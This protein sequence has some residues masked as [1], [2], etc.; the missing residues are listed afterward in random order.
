MK[1]IKK[2]ALFATASSVFFT[3]ISCLATSENST[4]SSTC[5][6]FVTPSGIKSQDI[7][8]SVDKLMSKFINK[9]I[10]GAQVSVTK[11]GKEVFSKG[12]GLANRKTPIPV[13]TNTSFNY[14]SVSKLFIWV[15]AMQLVEQGKLDLNKDIR[16]YLPKDYPLHITSKKPVTFLNLMNHNAGFEAFWKYYGGSGGSRDFSSLE[17][18]VHKCYSTIQCF[19]PGEF[20]GYSNFGANLAAL[21]I[22][23]ISKTPYF[24]YVDKNIFKPCKM[25]TCYPEREPIK[26]V[27]KNKATGYRF[28]RGNF[29]LTSVYSGDW[30]YPSGSAVGT[31]N[32]LSKFA[33][34]LMPEKSKKSPLFKSNK[35]LEEMF[36]ISYTP[37]GKDLFSMHHGFWGPN[38]NYSG[39]GHTGC[40]DGMVSHFVIV[41]KERFSVAVLVNDENG[42]DVAYG[43]TSLLTGSEYNKSR[44]KFDKVNT[45]T[46]EGDYVHARTRFANRARDFDLIHVK[47]LANGHDIELKLNNNPQIYRQIEP[48]LFENITATHGI[49]YK[50]KIYFKVKNGSVEKI[51]TFKNDLIPISKL[52]K[53]RSKF[54]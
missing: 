10:S 24:E 26:N 28:N 38:G 46:L 3:P 49:D 4:V 7:E 1:A 31:A 47:S 39:M 45:K 32:D 17:E 20:Q 14:A 19:K 27:M 23:K 9:N 44:I 43:V 42:W 37:T 34:A 51:V 30:L 22:E 36:K 18:A 53:F 6:N 35:T 13:D 54:N 33:K 11:D 25:Q 48:Y 15:S 16:T 12:Y 2:L 41:P 5:S 52:K 40:V 8:S 29:R 21:I 50:S